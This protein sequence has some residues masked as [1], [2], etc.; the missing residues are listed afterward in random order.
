MVATSSVSKPTIKLMHATSTRSNQTRARIR[1]EDMSDVSA[2]ARLSVVSAAHSSFF[3][4]PSSTSIATTPVSITP[5]CP[6]FLPRPAPR[7]VPFSLKLCEPCERLR[8][9]LP[10]IFSC[11]RGP[12]DTRA[13]DTQSFPTG[14]SACTGFSVLSRSFCTIGPTLPQVSRGGCGSKLYLPVQLTCTL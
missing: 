2:A 13:A 6:Y 11:V 9:S 7:R 1:L 14:C 8:H 10:W 5:T 12:T 4:L 3:R